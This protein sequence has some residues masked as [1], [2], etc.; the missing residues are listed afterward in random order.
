MNFSE[1]KAVIFDFD[2]VFTNNL[3][4]VNQDGIESVICN[5]SDG[6]GLKRLKELGIKTLIVSTEKNPVVTQ[7]AIKLEVEVFQNVQD[8]GDFINNWAKN[9]NLDLRKIAFLG[10][11]INDIAAFNL[12][13]FPIAVNDCYEEVKPF[14][15]MILSKNGGNGAVR[16]LCDLIYFSYE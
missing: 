14:V 7:R 6:L 1:I 10:N 16:E 11:D 3:V 13:G 4:I 2:G 8:K 5:R 9:L 15:K 12:V